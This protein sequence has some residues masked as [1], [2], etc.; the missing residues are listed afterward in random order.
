[1]QQTLLI[2]WWRKVHQFREAHGIVGEAVLYCI[3]ENKGLSDLSIQ[4]LKKFSHIFEEDVYD[5]I[6]LSACVNGRNVIGGPGKYSISTQLKF[7][8]SFIKEHELI[9]FNLN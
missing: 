4:E 2:T 9:N 8:E 6:N 7:L 1:M 5:A 3:K